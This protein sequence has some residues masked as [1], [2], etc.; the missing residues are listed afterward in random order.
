MKAL[1][2][3][4]HR[5]QVEREA[6]VLLAQRIEVLSTKPWREAQASLDGLRAD[7]AQWQQQAAQLVGEA[8][9]DS[10]DPKYPAQLDAS[11]AQL[12]LVWEAFDAALALAVAAAR[13]RTSPT[14][15]R[16]RV[17]R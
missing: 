13:R 12:A 10:L 16:A 6:A 5:V 2:D 14:A 3:L 1:E 4:Q 15:R 17:G 9:W 8:A 11:R 7:V